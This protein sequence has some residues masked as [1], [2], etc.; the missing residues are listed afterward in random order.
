M[1]VR[2]RDI[3]VEGNNIS[4]QSFC[5]QDCGLFVESNYFDTEG[6]RID[7]DIIVSSNRI[8]G[9]GEPSHNFGY[10]LWPFSAVG[11]K[12]VNVSKGRVSDNVIVIGGNGTSDMDN[13]NTGLWLHDVDHVKVEGN[14]I[15]MSSEGSTGLLI[16]EG[17]MGRYFPRLN[18]DN[19]I[20]DNTIMSRDD[21]SKC[22]EISNISLN[23]TF[24][25]NSLYLINGSE[26]TFLKASNKVE[27]TFRF[28]STVRNHSRGYDVVLTRGYPFFPNLG[29]YY[30]PNITV[31]NMK[32]LNAD[33]M[34]RCKLDVMQEYG[35]VSYDSSGLPMS[36]VDYSIENAGSYINTTGFGGDHAVNPAGCYGPFLVRDRFFDGRNDPVRFDTT[37]RARY[38]MDELWE[39]TRVRQV[40]ES[41]NEVFHVPDFYRPRTPADLEAEAVSGTQDVHVSWSPVRYHVTDYI[42]EADLGSGWEL[43]STLDRNDTEFIHED[44]P[45]DL[46]IGYRVAA[47][48]NGLL[49]GFSSPVEVKVGDITPPSPPADLEILSVDVSSI[50]VGWAVPVDPDVTTVLISIME[51]GH[52]VI[53]LSRNMSPS[54]NFTSFEGLEPDAQYFITVCFFDDAGHFSTNSTYARTLRLKGTLHIQVFYEEGTP[55]SGFGQNLVV[56]VSGMNQ[57]LLSGRTDQFGRVAILGI[58]VPDTLVVRVDPPDELKGMIGVRSGYFGAESGGIRLDRN[59]TESNVTLVLEYY[60]FDSTGPSGMIE[61]VVSYPLSGPLSGCVP[62]ANVS[63]VSLNRSVFGR[64][65]TDAYGYFTF[66]GVQLNRYFFVLAYPPGGSDSRYTSVESSMIYLDESSSRVQIGLVLG[67]DAPVTEMPCVEIVEYGP[68]GLNVD[69]SNVIHVRFSHRIT[70]VSLLNMVTTDPPLNKPDVYLSEDGKTLYVGHDDLIPGIRYNVSVSIMLEFECV[71]GLND[72]FKWS[73]YTEGENVSLSEDVDD[74]KGIDLLG[75]LIPSFLV[76]LCIVLVIIF[77][78]IRRN[79]NGMKDT[80]GGLSDE[81]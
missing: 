13:K 29:S 24:R 43:V 19:E 81:M 57:T 48:N 61:G 26:M 66:T 64:T 31:V 49:S 14:H 71:R 37:V 4:F 2:G 70:S 39:E 50:S 72:T 45:Q 20:V 35:A 6:I 5:D 73:F 47:S 53:L 30:G 78:L 80:T 10:K 8:F 56:E 38:M 79:R 65:R 16:G 76:L 63:L 60:E 51:S 11:M 21:R 75:I 22:M 55:E 34:E 15:S 7:S 25:D 52:D 41:M 3:R 9:K 28:N 54:R 77:V 32:V 27:G 62:F 12:L 17:N 74:E 59:R 69:V 67:Y 23:N 68:L 33:V 36:D 42:L 1:A 44:L 40:N 18:V 58:T 46:V